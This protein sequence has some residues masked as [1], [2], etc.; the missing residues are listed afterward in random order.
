[1]SFEMGAIQFAMSR[2]DLCFAI[3]PFLY[4]LEYITSYP[5]MCIH[6][7]L[8][9]ARFLGVR[10]INDYSGETGDMREIDVIREEYDRFRERVPAIRREKNARIS[11]QKCL[12]KCLF[13]ILKCYCSA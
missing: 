3:A 1:M 8:R 11:P 6:I 12:E 2:R 5:H 9:R 13:I 10:M 7:I 4:S